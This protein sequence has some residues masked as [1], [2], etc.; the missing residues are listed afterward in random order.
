MPLKLLKREKTHC[1][2]IGSAML[3]LIL[4]LGCVGTSSYSGDDVK[5][6][7]LQCVKEDCKAMICG[8]SKFSL[9]R[10]VS[11]ACIAGA[12]QTPANGIPVGN[13][14]Q[15]TFSES[16]IGLSKGSCIF[17]VLDEET[18]D[19][20]SQSKGNLKIWNFLLGGGTNFE[21]SELSNYLL[22]ASDWELI[23]AA[24]YAGEMAKGSSERKK[25]RFT[26]YLDFSKDHYRTVRYVDAGAGKMTLLIGDYDASNGYSL[27]V[28][29]RFYKTDGTILN[30]PSKVPYLKEDGF[31]KWTYQIYPLDYGNYEWG[32]LGPKIDYDYYSINLPMQNSGSISDF[33]NNGEEESDAQM[34]FECSNPSGCLSGECSQTHYQRPVCT[35]VDNTDPS[36]PKYYDV[37][38]GC[39]SSNGIFCLFYNSPATD[40]IWF[41]NFSLSGMRIALYGP[42]S[43][44]SDPDGVPIKINDLS[45]AISIP[46][47]IDWGA[48]CP[49]LAS[50]QQWLMNQPF[51][52]CLDSMPVISCTPFVGLQISNIDWKCEK[53][54]EDKPAIKS[55]GWCE[56]GEGWQ[57]TAGQHVY[58]LKGHISV[59][60][61]DDDFVFIGCKKSGLTD[62]LECTD[63]LKY[64]PYDRRKDYFPSHPWFRSNIKSLLEKNTIPVVLFTGSYEDKDSEDYSVVDETDWKSE[65]LA[66]DLKGMGPIILTTDMHAKKIRK[67]LV[68]GK[69]TG[70]A[71]ANYIAQTKAFVK[72]YKAQC[73]DCM[74]ALAIYGE[75][76]KRN[77]DGSIAYDSSNYAQFYILDKIF[78]DKGVREMVDMVAQ[79]T[80][81]NEYT[82]N[83]G[84]LE[85]VSHD[86]STEQGITKIYEDILKRKTEYGQELLKKYSKPSYILYYGSE[87]EKTITKTEELPSS[88]NFEDSPGSS[89]RVKGIVEEKEFNFACDVE[90]VVN[91]G[92]AE[93]N[94]DCGSDELVDAKMHMFAADDDGAAWIN[95]KFIDVFDIN[96]DIKSGCAVLS[97]GCHKSF[98]DEENEY[99][100][101]NR[102]CPVA[103]DITNIVKAGKNN[104][105]VV[106]YNSNGG[107]IWARAK[108]E[109]SCGKFKCWQNNMSGGFLEYLIKDNARS[110]TDSGYVGLFYVSLKEMSIEEHNASFFP[111]QYRPVSVFSGGFNIRENLYYSYNKILKYSN[112]EK[113]VEMLRKAYAK[114][115][116]SCTNPISSYP[117]ITGM[118]AETSGTCRDSEECDTSDG[119]APAAEDKC[120]KECMRERNGNEIPLES[121]PSLFYPELHCTLCSSLASPNDKVVCIIRE[122]EN[123]L[124]LKRFDLKNSD[125]T[126]KNVLS[127]LPVGS[128]HACCLTETDALG[129]KLT[130]SYTKDVASLT[131]KEL[132]VF[133]KDGNQ[134]TDCGKV[135]KQTLERFVSFGITTCK[136]E[137]TDYNFG[138]N[139]YA[140]GKESC[141]GICNGGVA[142]AFCYLFVSVEDEGGITIPDNSLIQITGASTNSLKTKDGFVKQSI[143]IP[144]AGFSGAGGSAGINIEVKYPYITGMPQP[145][146]N[147]DETNRGACIIGVAG[148]ELTLS[149]S[150]NPP[151]SFPGS[152][153]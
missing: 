130:Y 66:K 64:D 122:W 39:Y 28:G 69:S 6:K 24:E 85:L 133:P 62:P 19:K 100:L 138:F 58:L 80:I 126:Y 91:V 111:N 116:C 137:S 75:D 47:N 35:R 18:Y 8:S 17:N 82:L 7:N 144:Q 61:N 51:Y 94:I 129:E 26:N 30:Y 108:L 63:G 59:A 136:E 115:K 56:P 92:N 131:N 104:I 78:D 152:C 45:S 113:S 9:E 84:P 107:S 74:I 148:Q 121:D 135:N 67:I 60:E 97:M 128:V 109:Y 32:S 103:S 27:N 37:N 46:W 88:G 20:I 44:P 77:G 14:F 101:G 68:D 34:G 106:A 31:Y 41:L 38:C 132:A 96:D 123:T 83:G 142:G 150:F 22:P 139:I 2:A 151:S 15:L 153:P 125:D 4:L 1:A 102:F 33:L 143:F 114:D 5:M 54:S 79:E 105:N 76:M 52:N 98:R 40:K 146:D 86:C 65:Y 87:P 81:L 10:P 55:Y 42:A 23:K 72:Y 53:D 25:E 89:S 36:N 120:E 48:N 16:T 21:E 29:E 71:D 90:D 134:K 118:M 124:D 145:S 12:V 110:L 141:E 117:E 149:Y 70:N 43:S 127:A 73:P 49:S 140:E 99:S 147:C 50:L 13:S 112:Q 93:F 3:M 95:G 57:N 119:T 11:S